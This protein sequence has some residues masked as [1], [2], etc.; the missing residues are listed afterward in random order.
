MSGWSTT[1]S[2]GAGRQRHVRRPFTTIID[3]EWLK[4]RAEGADE[5]QQGVLSSA[6]IESR[7][8]VAIVK[9]IMFAGIPASSD[10]D[11]LAIRYDHS[12]STQFWSKRQ[13]R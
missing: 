9:V 1:A 8:F 5:E 3:Q 12:R 11:L 13:G 2:V 6:R 7:V 10:V 4:A